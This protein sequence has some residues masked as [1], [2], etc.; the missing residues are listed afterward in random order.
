MYLCQNPTGEVSTATLCQNLAGGVSAA[1]LCQNPA[2]E[3]SAAAL[4]Q[5][6]VVSPPHL[7]RDRTRLR[8]HRTAF[9]PSNVSSCRLKWGFVTTSAICHIFWLLAFWHWH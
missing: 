4:R 3:V 9:H 1:K 7:R 2:G 8:E 5:A 6:S